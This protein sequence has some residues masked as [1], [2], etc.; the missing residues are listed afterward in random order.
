MTTREVRRIVRLKPTTEGAGVHLHRGFGFG[1]TEDFDPFL[2]FDDFTAHEAGDYQAGFPWHPHRGIETVTYILKGEV[3]HE[4]SLGNK[5]SIGAGDIQW[6]SAG[7]G[8]VH[9]EMPVVHDG[10]VQGFQL[11]VNLP[12]A[13]KMSAPRYQ[14]ITRDE[15]F[16]VNRD[17]ATV[18]VIA[19]S[20]GDV[21]GPVR[22]IAGSPTYLDISLEAGAPFS[23]DTKSEDALF[24]YVILGDV[25][26]GDSSRENHVRAQEIALTTLG[27]ML[28]IKAGKDGAR[29]LLVSGTPLREP[30]A[31]HGPIVMNTRE[32]LQIAFQELQDGTFIKEKPAR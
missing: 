15:V 7:S 31:W 2:L 27:D 14:G 32:E 13:Q 24:I 22:D 21:H 29:L 8:I 4:D 25:V 28:S 30:I 26:F 3:A 11:W 17:K 18:R 16:E 9:Q 5:G 10:G 23:Y 19:G 1:D 6:M 12:R 20:F